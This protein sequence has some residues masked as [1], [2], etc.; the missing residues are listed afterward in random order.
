MWVFWL[1]LAA[2]QSER[3]G[4]AASLE[5]YNL[6]IPQI[7]TLLSQKRVAKGEK[8]EAQAEALSK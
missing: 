3:K 7:L 8:K 4:Y 1:F 2:V 5:I 6:E